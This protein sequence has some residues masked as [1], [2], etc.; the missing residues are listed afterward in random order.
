MSWRVDQ[1]A[2]S[3]FKS[4]NPEQQFAYKGAECF[5]RGGMAVESGTGTRA[6]GRTRGQQKPTTSGAICHWH[7]NM[8]R[9]TDF[10][11]ENWRG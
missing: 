3:C 8:P 11:V 4:G 2:V 6:T 7:I 5:A 9:E 10:H 1:L